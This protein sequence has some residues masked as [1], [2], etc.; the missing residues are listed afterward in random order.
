[1]DSKRA[2]IKRFA[3][4]ATL[5]KAGGCFFRVIGDEAQVTLI[6]LIQC[7]EKKREAVPLWWLFDR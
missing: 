4:V 2:F 1:M 7:H 3:V 6:L 5:T